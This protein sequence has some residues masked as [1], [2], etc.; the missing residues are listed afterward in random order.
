MRAA[1]MSRE[2]GQVTV[3]PAP[4]EPESS[5]TAAF[6]MFEEDADAGPAVRY[7]DLIDLD[8]RVE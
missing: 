5:N 8:V 3:M 1:L 4:V 2:H 7:P 6:N